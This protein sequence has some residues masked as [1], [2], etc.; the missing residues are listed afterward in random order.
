MSP[1]EKKARELLGRNV[2]RTVAAELLG[3][4]H[5]RFDALLSEWGIDWSNQIQAQ[6][7]TFKGKTATFAEHAKNLGIP[8][9]TLRTRYKD[10][11]P[12]DAPKRRVITAA[13]VE[14]FAALRYAGKSGVV[15]AEEVGFHYNRLHKLAV[16]Q[17]Q[18]YRKKIQANPR[19]RRSLIEL[20]RK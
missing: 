9:S 16:L 6:R 12:L 8:E 11:T 20:N 14:K 19:K 2:A 15:A 17:C 7:I 4:G 13:D 10:K 3:I 18:D 1:M 5:E